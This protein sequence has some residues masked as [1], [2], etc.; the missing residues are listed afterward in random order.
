M[1][2]RAVTLYLH[3]YFLFVC[4]LGWG[5]GFIFCK[6]TWARTLSVTAG[7]AIRIH[8]S[9]HCHHLTSIFDQELK[10]CFK[11]L[12]AEATQYQSLS[13]GSYRLGFDSNPE[14]KPFPQL[15]IQGLRKYILR[16]ALNHSPRQAMPNTT[17]PQEAC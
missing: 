1:H 8:S 12:Q 16:P 14:D 9:P 15:N 13:L 6:A 17:H 7:L 2:Y 3:H 4:M 5:G 10:S 11:T